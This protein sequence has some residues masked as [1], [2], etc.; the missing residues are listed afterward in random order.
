VTAA[1]V[2]VRSLLAGL[3]LK[4]NARD[5]RSLLGRIEVNPRIVENP[6]HFLPVLDDGHGEYVQAGR[7]PVSNDYCGKFMGRLVCHNKECHKGVVHK[8]VDFTDMN[9]VMNSFYHC[10]KAVCVRCFISGFS[11][12][13]AQVVESRIG[14]A[15]ERGCG[16]PEHIVLS[17]PKSLRGLPF[18]E[19]FKLG[20]VV[21]RDRGVTGAGLFPHGRR[22]DRK[23]RML[24]WSPHIHVIGFIAGGFGRCRECAHGRDDCKVC[25]GFKG[26]Q[27]RGY[28]KD[29]WIVKVEP[30]RKTVFGT[31]FY[32]L[33]HVSVKVGL[34][35][36][37]AVRWVGL[38]GNR[39]FKGVKGKCNA[40]C[41]VCKVAGHYS[42]M[43]HDAYWGKKPLSDSGCN[44]VPDVDADGSPNFPNFEGR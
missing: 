2:D 13:E 37:H 27:V 1:S 16:V 42:K 19:L 38:L 36:F 29:G 35:R 3:H 18:S 11:V 22:I 12:R 33:H 8:E 41:P 4:L 21:L 28:E 24:V 7:M 20:Y 14:E 25:D 43:E 44:A 34:F 26:R 5:T 31:A 17:P 32:I 6:Y 30:P 10:H 9:V 39:V 15:V 40:G 23:L